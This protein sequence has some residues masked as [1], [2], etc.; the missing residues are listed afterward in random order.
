MTNIDLATALD[1]LCLTRTEFATL[2]G[3][4]PETVSRW[5]REPGAKASLSVPTYAQTIILLL[6]GYIVD[7]VL[8]DYCF[9]RATPDWG[10]IGQTIA[11][12]YPNTLD[13]LR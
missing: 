12:R 5:L 7:T 4:A 1:D 13:K 8:A 10:M 9:K 3:V 2:C 11:D 6:R